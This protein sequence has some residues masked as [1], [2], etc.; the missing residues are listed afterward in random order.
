MY[1]GVEF[2]SDVNRAIRDGNLVFQMQE[3]ECEVE[4]FWEGLYK[5]VLLVRVPIMVDFD[6]RGR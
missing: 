3:G 5:S 1:I 2:R 4:I 6:G